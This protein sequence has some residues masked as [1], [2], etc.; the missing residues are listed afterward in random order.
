VVDVGVAGIKGSCGCVG[1]EGVCKFVMLSLL[2]FSFP[3]RKSAL[4]NFFFW[5]LLWRFLYVFIPKNT[6][7]TKTS[8]PIKAPMMGP[9]GTP[10][11][12]EDEDD[13]LPLLGSALFVEVVVVGELSEFGPEGTGD[14]V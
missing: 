1:V 6:N 7:P 8:R 4:N 9:T 12:E 3:F 11:E 13:V 14:E 10:D 2:L 5:L